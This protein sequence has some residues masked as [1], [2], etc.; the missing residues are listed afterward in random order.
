ME[1]RIPV[2]LSECGKDAGFDTEILARE[3]IVPE[4]RGLKICGLV[5]PI[6]SSPSI[7]TVC[8]IILTMYMSE[9]W[10]VKNAYLHK[11]QGQ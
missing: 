3:E 9:I 10:R 2:P 7:H 6:L 11:A 4:R 5:Y 8:I 1:T